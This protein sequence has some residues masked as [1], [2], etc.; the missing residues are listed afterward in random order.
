MFNKKITK[1]VQFLEGQLDILNTTIKSLTEQLNNNEVRKNKYQSYE[2]QVEQSYLMYNGLADYGNDTLRG[3]VDVRA[4]FIGGEGVKL[5]ATNKNKKK[6]QAFLDKLID[7]NDLDGEGF[8]DIVETAEL[9]GKLLPILKVVDKEKVIIRNMTWK[10]NKYVV[11]TDAYDPKKII[12][13]KYKDNDDKDKTIPLDKAVYIKLGG[14]SD[15]TNKTT[16]KIGTVLTQ[17]ENYDRALYDLRENN[18]LFGKV[19]PYFKC[20]D[21]ESANLINQAIQAKDF[22]VGSGYAGTAEFKYISPDMGAS[23]NLFKEITLNVK[24]ITAVT[25]VLIHWLGWPELMS[26]RATAENMLEQINAATKKDRLKLKKGIEELVQKAMVLA[27]EANLPEAVNE[28]EGFEVVIPMPSIFQ[29]EQIMSIY[30]PFQQADIISKTT[31]QNMTPG[32]DSQ[33]ENK[34]MQS[35]KEENIKNNPLMQMIGNNGQLDNLQNNQNNNNQNN[36]E[37]NNERT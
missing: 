1:K 16:T 23:D 8:I 4:A 31:L 11:K 24:K 22:V 18:H 19:T 5:I 20:E 13:I 9:E 28:P 30:F 29:L 21:Q 36:Q 33:T 15:K 17:I 37:V 6:T 3:L 12:S 7:D 2:K 10:T 27:T 26:N 32:I 34:L 14:T 35:E 25:G